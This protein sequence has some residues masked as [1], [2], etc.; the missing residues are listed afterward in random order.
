MMMTV[1]RMDPNKPL[2]TLPSSSGSRT[3]R[4]IP[5]LSALV[6]YELNGRLYNHPDDNH[7]FRWCPFFVPHLCSSS[8]ALPLLGPRQIGPWWLFVTAGCCCC[9]IQWVS[10]RHHLHM[11]ARVGVICPNQLRLILRPVMQ[12]EWDWAMDKYGDEW[13]F[14]KRLIFVILH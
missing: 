7:M 4:D 2:S 8:A 6:S 5:I 1:G 3:S 14:V 9:R 13:G 11:L 12:S 10:P